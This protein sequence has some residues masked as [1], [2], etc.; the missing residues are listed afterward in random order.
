M[1]TITVRRAYSFPHH[2]TQ[3]TVQE[4]VAYD[5]VE[6]L[7]EADFLWIARFD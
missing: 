1:T 2:I 7:T 4:I 3:L 6:K 5:A